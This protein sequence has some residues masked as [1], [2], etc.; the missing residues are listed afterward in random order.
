RYYG[1]RPPY[2]YPQ[3]PTAM[4]ARPGEI[5]SSLGRLANVD[6]KPGG[7]RLGTSTITGPWLFSVG[8]R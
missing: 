5:H 2:G 3:P 6:R 4:T 1:V 7:Q 8:I